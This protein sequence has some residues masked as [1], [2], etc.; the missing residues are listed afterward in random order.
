MDKLKFLYDIYEKV[1]QRQINFHQENNI[2]SA[3]LCKTCNVVP[4]NWSIKNKR[5]SEFCSS[6][7]AHSHN[8]TRTKIQN[9]C[10]TKYGHTT[11]LKSK[12]TKEKI[13]KT[14]LAK[15][16]VENFSKTEEFKLK[17]TNTVISRYGVTNPSKLPSVKKKIDDCHQSRYNRK[18]FSQVHI[19]ID[20]VNLKNNHL[21]MKRL[22]EELKMPVSEIAEMLGINHSQLCV[23]F[24]Q[25]LG[26]DIS[27]HSV[28]KSERE[29][30]D[31][32]QSF[33]LDIIKSDRKIIS[34]KELDL[35]IL[36]KNLAIE[37]NGLAWHTE[38][39]G[40]DK[41]YHLQK[42]NMCKEKNIRLVHILDWEWNNKKE[43]V[44]SRIAGIL[45]CNN[46]IYAR[47]TKVVA[48]SKKQADEFFNA[49]HIQGTCVAKIIYGLEYKGNIVA[50]MSFGKPRFNQNYEWELIR[51]SNSLYTT[52]VGGASKLFS[53]FLK[54]NN[55]SSIISYSDNRWNTGNLYKK[56]GFKF[57]KN[58][59]PNYWYTFQYNTL[60]SRVAYQKHKLKNKIK[61][62]DE[63]LTEWENLANNGYDR[64][65][66]CGNSVYEYIANP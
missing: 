19:P 56:L 29:I 52:V 33:N 50:A 37:V 47:K 30:G 44:K 58:T 48:L 57:I 49:T 63:S 14:C 10:L 17:Y 62:F 5:Y 3:V 36:D 7:C 32:I 8:S 45:N 4:V 34:P 16:G 20:I 22:Y 27:R 26:I 13:K 12:E 1:P 9:T 2:F 51:F 43:I 23:H 28:S 64:F 41:Y 25:N 18:R 24:K 65:W 40:K 66:D 61:F 54:N 38:L 55:S 42:T 31:Y 11:N 46:T 39:R 21:E 60:E 59:D 6:K 35:L 15:Y 53:Y